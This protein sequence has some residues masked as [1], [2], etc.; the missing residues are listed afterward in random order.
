MEKTATVGRAG[1]PQVA[2]SDQKDIYC[3]FKT[4]L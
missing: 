3:H 4:Q 2:L 1:N